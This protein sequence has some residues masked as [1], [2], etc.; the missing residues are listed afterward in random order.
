MIPHIEYIREEIKKAYLDL[1]A[2][3]LLKPP[4]NYFLNLALARLKR[5]YNKL[6]E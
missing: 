2:Q 6:G 3:L 1:E 5:L 4:D